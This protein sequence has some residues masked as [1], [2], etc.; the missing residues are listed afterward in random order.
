MA[1]RLSLS[2][3]NATTKVQQLQLCRVEASYSVDLPMQHG[4]VL[5]S[6]IAI[7]FFLLGSCIN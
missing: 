6:N 5:V 1:S 7:I 3:Q 4:V 2:T